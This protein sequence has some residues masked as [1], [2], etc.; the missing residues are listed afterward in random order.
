[1]KL[2]ASASLCMMNMWTSKMCIR[3]REYREYDGNCHQLYTAELLQ[4]ILLGLHSMC[5]GAEAQFFNGHTLSLIH[6]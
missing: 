3:D 5:Q 6:I 4:E 2:D 1:M